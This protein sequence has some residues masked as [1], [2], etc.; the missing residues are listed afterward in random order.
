MAIRSLE[1]CGMFLIMGLLQ[2]TNLFRARAALV[3][4]N[5]PKELV[6]IDTETMSKDG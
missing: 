3:F 1:A 4:M 5:Q 6:Y 2:R